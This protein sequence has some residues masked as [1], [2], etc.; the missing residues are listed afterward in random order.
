MSRGPFVPFDG[1]RAA[2]RP[3]VSLGRQLQAN[4]AHTGS[5]HQQGPPF[6]TADQPVKGGPDDKED[7]LH[8]MQIRVVNRATRTSFS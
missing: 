3:T 6:V 1:E 7:H 2:A 5:I 4:H 8:N